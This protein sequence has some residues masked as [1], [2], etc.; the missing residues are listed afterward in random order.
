[1]NAREIASRRFEKSAFGY[2]PEEVDSY[3]RDISNEFA[4][5]QKE[6]EDCDKKI[7]VLADKVREYMQDEEALKDAIMSAQRQGRQVIEESKMTANRILAEAN[8]K[9]QS[10]VG[11]TSYQLEKEK[12][13]LESVKKEVSDFKA[14]LLESYR[15]HIKIL[16][17]IP[18]YEEGEEEAATST[19][20]TEEVRAQEVAEA[21][22]VTEPAPETAP[23]NQIHEE[24]EVQTVSAAAA[25]E[26]FPSNDQTRHLDLKFG[27]NNK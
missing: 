5:L 25:F 22:A 8:E 12:Q 3:L 27:S 26:A 20:A 10:V 21:E 1:M 4:A 11:Q 14:K 2:K 24:E 7:E 16:Q 9:A 18:D 6:K 15:D 19:P 17:A 23:I 13:A